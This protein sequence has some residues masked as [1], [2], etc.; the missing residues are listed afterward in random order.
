MKIRY[1]IVTICTII[2]GQSTISAF[3]FKK[4]YTSII[5]PKLHQEIA[6]E[7]YNPKNVTLLRLK[8][9]N[10]N[11][12]VKTDKDHTNI[13][14]KA[15]KKSPE[16]E[17]LPNL[18]FSQKTTGNQ[19]HI[20]STYDE[21]T[22]DGHIDFELIVPQKLALNISTDQGDILLKQNHAPCILSTQKGSIDS[23]DAWN[24]IDASTHK[25]TI[26]FHKPRKHIKAHATKGNIFIYDAQESVIAHSDYG[27]VQMFAKAIPSTSTIKL[28]T[29]TGPILLHLPPDVNADL[30][31]STKHGTITSDHFITLKPQTTQLNRH[32]WKRLQKEIDGTLGTGEAQIKLSSVRS[33]IKVIEIKA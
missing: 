19:M 18:T 1:L 22:V 3:S 29:V 5:P 26:A 2:C 23:I 30:Q 12:T 24:T 15:I 7:E 27:T 9:K 32:A 20:E 8:N 21:N 31:A 13:F 25:G 10:G 4:L 6:Y 11:V 17:M 16:P 28:T 33:D 14:L